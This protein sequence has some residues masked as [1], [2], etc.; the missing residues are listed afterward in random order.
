MMVLEIRIIIIVV[1]SVNPAQHV[2]EPVGTRGRVGNP[3]S[4][5][6]RWW[7]VVAVNNA[8]TCLDRGNGSSTSSIAACNF[9]SVYSIN[10][11]NSSCE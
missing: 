8:T 6:K 9:S 11:S 5:Q 3:K 4:W 2:V 10:L 7:N 1:S